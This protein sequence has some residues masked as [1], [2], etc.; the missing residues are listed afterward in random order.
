M[1]EIEDAKKK[2]S[3]EETLEEITRQFI[4]GIKILGVESVVLAYATTDAE[5]Q[6][7]VG[8]ILGDSP[9]VLDLLGALIHSLHPEDFHSLLMTMM[10]GDFFAE[11]RGEK[12]KPVKKELVN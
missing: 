2:D 1:S 3:R 7:V 5:Q 8:K 12:E 9:M 10:C 11:Q 4:D 6:R